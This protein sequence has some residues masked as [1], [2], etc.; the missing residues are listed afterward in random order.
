MS[1][2]PKVTVPDTSKNPDAGL[3][4]I[5]NTNWYVSYS[6]DGKRRRKKIGLATVTVARQKRTR[7]YNK[8]LAAGATV[9][10]KGPN[11]GDTLARRRQRVRENPERYLKHVSGLTKP[12]T[13]RLGDD[14]VLGPFET[15]RQ[16]VIARNAA[17]GLTSAK[18]GTKP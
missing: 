15:K 2:Q 3:I 14:V 10:T 5:D 1:K 12:W 7:F 11:P 4:L 8:L 16:A 6:V 9:A 17:I 13:V 18:G